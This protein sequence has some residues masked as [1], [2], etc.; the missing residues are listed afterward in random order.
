MQKNDDDDDER[1]QPPA[2]SRAAAA[3]SRNISIHDTFIGDDDNINNN[4]GLSSYSSSGHSSSL[5]SSGQLKFHDHSSSASDNSFLL[6]DAEAGR[7]YG[8][9]SF[10]IN[11]EAE[12]EGEGRRTT[13]GATTMTGGSNSS[14]GGDQGGGLSSNLARVV[15]GK[16]KWKSGKGSSSKGGSRKGGS[17]NERSFYTL[18]ETNARTFPETYTGADESG[19]DTTMRRQRSG[20]LRFGL[21]N[22]GSSYGRR[23]KKKTK[24][25]QQLKG[26]G[27]DE[28]ISGGDTT[29]GSTSED[30]VSGGL[31][32]IYEM[33]CCRLL[34]LL[35]LLLL[36]ISAIATVSVVMKKDRNGGNEEVVEL[37]GDEVV[38]L[39][40]KNELLPSLGGC[41]CY[42][43]LAAD[44][45]TPAVGGNVDDRLAIDG[46]LPLYNIGGAEYACVDNN[47]LT[48]EVAETISY[49]LTVCIF[50]NGEED[51]DLGGYVLAAGGEVDEF[52]M[53][54]TSAIT[55]DM[56]T[57]DLLLL[58]YPDDAADEGGGSSNIGGGSAF[59]VDTD[60]GGK[61]MALTLTQLITTFPPLDEGFYGSAE[62]CA[63]V[64]LE[65]KGQSKVRRTY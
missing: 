45:V 48:K 56:Q 9:E 20:T 55:G 59:R 32:G 14:G 57:H 16:F 46:E 8:W 53:D 7:C 22:V 12:D 2:D 62:L 6:D 13:K 10:K 34:P 26:G 33:C 39:G 40:V 51:D 3:S 43:H 17:N 38:E 31:A 29:S 64:P 19:E 52:T 58:N 47:H 27:L 41:L 11:Y 18:E 49:E 37:D 4:N 15:F 42:P 60:E 61:L 30:D 21:F 25:Q 63:S 44:D 35:A 1:H 28:D 65:Y 54:I 24:K 36:L 5:R 23:S 50:P